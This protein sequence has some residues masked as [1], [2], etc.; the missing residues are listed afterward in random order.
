MKWA[1]VALA[2]VLAFGTTA[3][4]VKGEMLSCV[5]N[6]MSGIFWDEYG[7]AK[8]REFRGG[9][10]FIVTVFPNGDRSIITATGTISYVCSPLWENA[11]PPVISCTGSNWPAPWLFKGN[12]YTRA[13]LYGKNIDGDSNIYVAYGTC[14]DF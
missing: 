8:S 1:L 5:D 10:Q 11:V 14:T 2:V 4:A 12:N 7:D 9:K 3:R 13:Y 6:K